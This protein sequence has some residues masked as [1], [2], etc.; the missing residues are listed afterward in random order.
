MG[1]LA[2]DLDGDTGVPGLHAVGE[3]A[4]NGVHGANRLASNSLLE[5]VACGRRLGAR[6]ATLPQ[7][8]K[9][10]GAA[11]WI[12]RGPSL[13]GTTLAA[14]RQWLWT[15]AGPQRDAAILSEALRACAAWHGWQARL[16][17]ALLLAAVRRADNL[18][19]H[20]RYD[21]VAVA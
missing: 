5:G 13:D 6:L 10:Q 4:C 3:V 20:W 2:T 11:R 15:A 14:L 16:G 9:G 18:G 1:G 8:P 17:E 12:E 19:A 7:M 21:A